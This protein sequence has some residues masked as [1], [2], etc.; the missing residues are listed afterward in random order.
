MK[1]FH[2]RLPLFI[3]LCSFS[4]SAV[5]QVMVEFKDN[6]SKVY[7]YSWADEFDATTLNTDKWMN[8][9]P[10]GRHLRC[11]PEV[12]YYSD[13]KD[14]ILENGFLQIQARKAPITTR[15]IPYENDDFIIS[16]KNKPDTKNLMNFEYQSGLIYSKEKFKYGHFE[17]RFKTD[18]SSGHWP[19]FWLFGGDGQEIDIFEIGAGK[20]NE[21]HVDVHCKSGCKNYPVFLGIF[22]KNWGGYLKTNATW[23]NEFHTMAATWEPGGVTW[24]LDDMPIAWWKGDFHEPLALIANMAVADFEGSLGGEILPTTKF[25]ALMQ[26]DYIRVWQE[27][28]TQKLRLK[29]NKHYDRLGENKEA[30]ILKKNRPMY[31]RSKI[32][33][34]FERCYLSLKVDRNLSIQR[35]GTAMMKRTMRI[36]KDKKVVYQKQLDFK[37]EVISLQSLSSGVY[38][39]QIGSGSQ[40]ASMELELP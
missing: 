27:S 21:V 7:D 18:A 30:K 38:E 36:L 37:N 15:A 22:K 5:S 32:K 12:N 25:P 6:K 11:N 23:P 16:C 24:Y 10:W 40:F 13:G 14:L 4:F 1:S 33:E 20:L 39:L 34:D 19:A 31:K 35:N 29:M 3:T 17:I 9:Y 2:L 28:S 8:S 26:V